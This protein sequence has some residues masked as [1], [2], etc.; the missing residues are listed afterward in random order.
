[1][2][3]IVL[4]GGTGTRL[5]PI[6]R[7]INKHL[8]PVYDKPLIYYAISL[9]MLAQIRD[10]L[11]ITNPHDQL[12]FQW[13]L[14]DGGQWGISLNYA[15]QA[16]PEGIAQAFLIGEQFIGSDSCALALGDNILFGSGLISLLKSAVHRK[17]GATV[18]CSHVEDPTQFGTVV[19][20]NSCQPVAI[21]EKPAD[22]RSNW[23]LIG[24]YFFDNRVIEFAQTVKSSARGELE[25][26][27]VIRRFL[28]CQQLEV[29][30][31]G[32]GFMWIDAGTHDNMLDASNFVRTVD[33]RQNQ[34]ILVPEEI[35]LINRWISEEQVEAQAFR[36][37]NTEY[38]D[39][40][41]KLVRDSTDRNWLL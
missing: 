33:K 23:A 37:H 34:K 31:L 10:I 4:G 12:R 3:G 32:R 21:E 29:E 16:K 30:T 7:G 13:L 20:D 17:T 41:L 38:G 8:L 2:K 18:F 35:A 27:D 15:V 19:F 22:P 9:L 1:M 25:I 5:L 36:H 14:G 24:L 40:L 6:T 39:Y 28:E 26:T 11:V